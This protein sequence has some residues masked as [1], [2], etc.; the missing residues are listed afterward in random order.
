MIFKSLIPLIITVLIMIAITT[1]L[2]ST[3]KPALHESLSIENA[4]LLTANTFIQINKS[5]TSLVNY[6]ACTV[7][8]N[9]MTY[10]CNDLLIN[11]TSN[12]CHV[13]S[14]IMNE[15]DIVKYEVVDYGLRGIGNSTFIVMRV[16]A[17]YGNYT[18]NS[19]LGTPIPS[20]LCSYVDGVRSLMRLNG[21]EHTI[22][23]GNISSVGS[24]VSS[25]I[26]SYVGNGQLLVNY[27]VIFRR[28]SIEGNMTYYQGTL[29]FSIEPLNL[30]IPNCLI[31]G[32]SGEA[33]ITLVVRG[34][35][36]SIYVFEVRGSLVT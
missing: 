18:I 13:L 34:N 10:T 8:N 22:I 4:Y 17:H 23:T 30:S 15:T 12:T 32:V 25:L 7:A 26:K 19:V 20:E 36:T 35:L 2:T 14:V 27:L 5:L 6:Y 24:L 16:V 1:Y 9:P 33:Y 28:V 21:T 3:L 11:I 29:Q 31:R